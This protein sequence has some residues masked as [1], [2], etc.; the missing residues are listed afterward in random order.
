MFTNAIITTRR[1]AVLASLA[2][3]VA[4]PSAAS[5]A[6]CPSDVGT[7]S[8]LPAGQPGGPET[9]PPLP[10]SLPPVGGD[11]G[12]I[13]PAGQPGAPAT[14]PAQPSGSGDSVIPAGQPGAVA[15]AHSVIGNGQPQS[16]AGTV[17][18]VRS[19]VHQAR[20]RRHRTTPRVRF[21]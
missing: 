18:V 13:M 14:P 2:T 4:L 20:H 12:S 7:P 16:R 17:V 5:A 1:V 3:V 15:P 8:V 9:A 10:T 11:S 6:C 21:G 19:A